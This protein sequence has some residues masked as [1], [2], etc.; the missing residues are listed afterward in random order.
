MATPQQQ[1]QQHTSFVL[2]AEA[3]SRAILEN[4][5]PAEIRDF[6]IDRFQEAAPPSRAAGGAG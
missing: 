3:V 6:A 2:E 4:E 5:A 1:Q